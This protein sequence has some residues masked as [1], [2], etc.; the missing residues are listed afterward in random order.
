[1]DTVLTRMRKGF[2]GY[3]L[4]GEVKKIMFIFIRT[5]EIKRGHDQSVQI[6]TSLT[7]LLS[8]KENTA[9]NHF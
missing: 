9:H 2:R 5:E 1:M 8:R 4:G 7:T 3:K 6:H